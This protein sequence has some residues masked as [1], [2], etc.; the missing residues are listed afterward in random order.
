MG[1]RTEQRAR[2][3][4][5]ALWAL[6]LVAKVALAARLP[7]FVDEAFYWQEGQHLAW[8]YSDLPGL[9]A[10]LTRI[11]TALFGHS[12]LALRLP[13]LLVAALIPWL[14]A[15]ITAREFGRK[16]GW[17]AASFAVLLPLAGTLGLLAV[18]DAVMV[19]AALLCV[20]AVARLLRAVTAGASVELA[21]GL[22]MGALSHYRFI[23]VLGVGLLVLLWLPAGRRL[24]R[25]PRVLIALALGAAAWTPLIAW[26]L[27][28]AEAGLRFQLVDRHPW[29]FH[30]DGAWF[31]A[32]Q[33]LLVTPLLL[34]ALGL[35]AWRHR[36]DA[37]QVRRLFALTGALIV[38]G[39][40]VL[41]F[42]ADTERV[43]FHWPLP[44]FVLLLPLLPGVLATWTPAW[45][46]ATFVV[47][48]LGLVSMLGYYA[49]VSAPSVRARVAAEKWYPGNFA[50]WDT[51]A[52]AVRTQRATMPP[53]TWIVADNFKIGAELGFALRDPNIQVLDHPLNRK[54]GRAPQLALWGLHST[55]RSDWGETP[56][57]LV[58]GATEVQYRELLARYHWLCRQVGPL[59]A[60]QVVNVDHGR[61]RFLLFALPEAAPRAKAACTAPAMAWFD[62][63]SAGASVQRRF[64]VTGWAFKDGV[65]L[66]R[67]EVLLDGQPVAQAQY[68]LS[69]P[70]TAA[71]WK[72]ST[73]PNHPR[74]GFK[75]SVDAS[76]LP[77]GRHWLGLRLH[78]RDGSVEDW[79]EQPVDLQ[80]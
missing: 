79:A 32:I 47:A 49:A 10:W 31:V 78:G 5:V 28:N 3:G 13:F 33:T 27:E 25:D 53:N 77:P 44:G 26:N 24:L 63:P 71:Y 16:A 11:G 58:F 52:D 46:R 61:Q 15:A 62:T 48:A 7:L 30:A 80:R 38:L 40:F 65:G 74:V 60:P 72:I 29:A 8:A 45:R 59:P 50:G 66:T 57:L 42:F 55:G 22:A 67:V 21:L 9:T 18:P 54:H 34:A 70:G 4:F 73:D 14:V 6:V 17:T 75:A 20:D 1:D 35:A 12:T 68:G 56:V 41:G 23:A 39:F 19:L 51:L 43:S 69:S 37:V 2:H 64:E 36:V 76:G